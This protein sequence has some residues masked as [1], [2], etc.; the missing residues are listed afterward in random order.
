MEMEIVCGVKPC[1]DAVSRDAVLSKKIYTETE[2]GWSGYTV[3][4]DY[5]EQLPSVT[6]KSG[7]WIEE[8]DDYGE[9]QGWHCSNCYED[10]GFTTD[11]ATEFCPNCGARMVEPQ[12]SEDINDKTRKN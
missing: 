6:Q 8:R 9:V 5:I 10:T 7:H 12:E 11:C 3:D 2:E 4:A 1:E